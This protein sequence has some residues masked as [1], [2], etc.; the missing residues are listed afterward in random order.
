MEIIS[1]TTN[2]EGK[3]VIHARY[4]A[5]EKAAMAERAAKAKAEFEA[6]RAEMLEKSKAARAAKTQE[7]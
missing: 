2:S 3:K 7:G 5:E 6:K 4:T 1:E